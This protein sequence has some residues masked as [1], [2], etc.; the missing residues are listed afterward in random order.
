MFCCV[1]TPSG[2][3]KEQTQPQPEQKRPA[4]PVNT[5]F[6]L[7]YI[8]LVSWPRRVFRSPH[9]AAAVGALVPSALLPAPP[10]LRAAEAHATARATANATAN[11]TA[12][13]A[14]AAAAASP[15]SAAVAAPWVLRAL[16]WPW[17][18][19]A[20]EAWQPTLPLRLGPPPRLPPASPTSPTRLGAVSVA[21]D[22]PKGRWGAGGRA[23]GAAAAEKAA[24][25]AAAP[26]TAANAE[27]GRAWAVLPCCGAAAGKRTSPSGPAFSSLSSASHLMQPSVR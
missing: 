2:G 10:P 27:A 9:S 11:A 1:H 18:P 4:W 6:S 14:S 22:G 19:M 24:V 8:S 5:G 16:L 26:E 12:A 3:W 13:A 25:E 15:P 17:H 20:P 21:T 7:Q 23:A